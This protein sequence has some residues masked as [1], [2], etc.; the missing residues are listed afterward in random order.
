VPFLPPEDLPN[1]GTVPTSLVSPVLTGR[2]FF[3]T[4]VLPEK[5]P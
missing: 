1:P 3:F 4:A 5:P 2:L